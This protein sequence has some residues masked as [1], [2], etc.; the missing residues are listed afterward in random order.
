MFRMLI[1]IMAD[2]SAKLS[3]PVHDIF[4]TVGPSSSADNP[5][6]RVC[7]GPRVSTPL[8]S[9]P[10]PNRK[11]KPLPAAC[12]IGEGNWGERV[13]GKFEPTERSVVRGESDRKGGQNE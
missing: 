9:L 10:S 12:W 8:V 5:T 11:L 2:S 6:V 7:S 4:S 13:D 1:S 3:E